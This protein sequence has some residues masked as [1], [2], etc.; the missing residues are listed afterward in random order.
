MSTSEGADFQSL[1]DYL[2][3]VAVW[4]TRGPGEFEYVSAGAKGIW[5]IPAEAIRR[6][7]SNLLDRIHPEDV[8]TVRSR[9]EAPPAEVSEE[10]YEARAV[11]PDGTVRW[12]Q[13]RQIPI[14]DDDGGL[15]RVIG[16][17]TDITEQKE[18]EQ[19]FEA[20]NRVLRH[21]I[22]NDM[23]ILIGWGSLL[24]EHVDDD[25]DVLLRKMLSAADHVVDLTEVARDY[26]RTI[27]GEEEMEVKP[28]SLRDTL[29]Q[30]VELR[31]EFFPAAAFDVVGEIPDVQVVAN[32]MLTSVFRNL[33]N[34][35][36]QHNDSDE[37]V[38][39][40][41]VDVRD[42]DV[43]VHIADNGPGIP[44][45]VR[46]TLFEEGTKGVDSP[47]TGLGLYLVKTL[48]DQYDGSIAV[49]ENEPTGTEFRISLSRAE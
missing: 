18:R 26:A 32:E 20:L 47:G 15:Q 42:E 16:I 13:T 34:N 25:G 19:E 14:R 8:E 12:V 9:I 39:E 17:C 43:I 35:A 45:D 4:V 40:I 36:V 24:D 41:G 22:R 11:H 49:A 23:S 29:T 30:E 31:R 5:G 3:G 46:D 27:A 7:P 1:I 37:P 28:V 2:D 44:P 38:V 48:L 10:S 6:D 33:L 21:D